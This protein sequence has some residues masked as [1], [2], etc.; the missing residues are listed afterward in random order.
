VE[1]CG[2]TREGVLRSYLRKRNSDER[3]DAV[4]YGLLP[5]ELRDRDA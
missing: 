4:V 5:H 3:R 2:F 1:R